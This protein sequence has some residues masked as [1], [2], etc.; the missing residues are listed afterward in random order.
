MYLFL[1]TATTGLNSEHD[2]IIKLSYQIEHNNAIVDKNIFHVKPRRGR[3]P[4]SI[5]K[6]ALDFNGIDI[7]TLRTYGDPEEACYRF[8]ATLKEVTN[9]GKDKL[10]VV[11]H[12]IKFDTDFLN[13]FIKLYTEYNL[14]SYIKFGGYDLLYVAPLIENSTRESYRDYKFATLCKQCSLHYDAKDIESKTE[15][16]KNLF[17]YYNKIVGY[18][19]S[20]GD[21]S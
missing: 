19:S 2:D 3:I 10:T 6:E 7:A 8:I 16:I 14:Y 4:S 15:N 21:F 5:A 13:N 11:G 17:D 18:N 1:A 20:V 9:K 12:N